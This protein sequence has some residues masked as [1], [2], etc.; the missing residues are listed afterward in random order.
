MPKKEK[1]Y[2][3]E[4]ELRDLLAADGEDAAEP[5]A[6]IE[7]EEG[8][9]DLG[10]PDDAPEDSADSPEP[11]EPKEPQADVPQEPIEPEEPA[12]TAWTGAVKSKWKDLPPEVR[13]EIKKREDDIHRMMTAHDGELRLGRSVKEIATPYEAVI[14]SEGGTIEGA[15]RDLLNTAYVLRT[16]SPQQ[17][18][19]L[20]MQTAQQFGVDLNQYNAQRQHGMQNPAYQ[21]LQQEVEQLRRMA[22]PSAIKSQL[23]ED[24][25]RDRITSEIQAFAAN[26]ENAHF[27]KVKTIMGSLIQSGQAKGLQDAYEKAI[28]ADPSIRNDLLSAQEREKAAKKKAEMAAKRKAAASVTGSPNGATPNAN[29][30]EKSIEDE[31]RE[32]M[33]AQSGLI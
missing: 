20:I 15:F 11:K 18:A 7:P 27:D 29:A 23:Q 17:K 21:A 33:K 2:T 26:P 24:M 8:A 9:D 3:I 22:D 5:D 16:G 13:T 28:W 32:S 19:E 25:E 30:P 12:P 6:P 1:D 31:I 4:D 10:E 14:R